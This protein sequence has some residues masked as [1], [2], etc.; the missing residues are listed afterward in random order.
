MIMRNARSGQVAQT[1]RHEGRPP[2]KPR[3]LARPPDGRTADFAST[4]AFLYI[5]SDP[6]QI[7]VAPSAIAAGCAAVRRGRVLTRAG[8][9]LPDVTLTILDHP[10]YGSTTTCA[11]GVFDMVVNGGGLL[12]V[13]C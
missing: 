8:A 3:A 10:E 1:A 13:R 2:A 9:P 4:I 7:G 12:T 6:V 5:G 11:D